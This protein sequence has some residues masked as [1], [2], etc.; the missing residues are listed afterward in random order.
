ME[1]YRNT[2]KCVCHHLCPLSITGK[3]VLHLSVKG[4]KAW[5]SLLGRVDHHIHA[6]LAD[7]S[8]T[9]LGGDA[10]LQHGKHPGVHVD[11]LSISSSDATLAHVSLAAGHEAGTLQLG[12][13]G[14]HLCHH[15]LETVEA[16][17]LG[18]HIVLVHL[19]MNNVLKYGGMVTS[20][21]PGPS[22]TCY[23]ALSQG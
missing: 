15:L 5:L 17:A 19:T 9:Q 2:V 8:G 14:A 4:S 12:V 16:G 10:L 1:S 7:D 11:D 18:I 3:S 20:V 6:G 23:Q 22:M 13:G 21:R